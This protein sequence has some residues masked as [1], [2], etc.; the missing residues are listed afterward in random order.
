[1]I[2]S[3]KS[4]R[5]ARKTVR[6][7]GCDTCPFI[8]GR[9]GPLEPFTPH[10]IPVDG[11]E[12]VDAYFARAYLWD[13]GKL[14][15]A[16]ASRRPA[17]VEDAVALA[18]WLLWSTKPE[19]WQRLGIGRGD[20][21]RAVLAVRGL[22]R[23][24]GWRD[25]LSAT[26][27]GQR[28]HRYRPYAASMSVRTEDPARLVA[29]AEE[30]SHRGLWGADV[31]KRGPRKPGL[32]KTSKKEALAAIVG[33]PV[34]E[35]VVGPIAV[36]GGVAW[37]PNDGKM[38]EVVVREVAFTF[39]TGE[40]K[41]GKWIPDG[42]EEQLCEVETEWKMVAGQPKRQEWP[43]TFVA[44][45]VDC[46]NERPRLSRGSGAAVQPD[47]WTAEDH[48]T[49]ENRKPAENEWQEVAPGH[50]VRLRG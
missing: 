40:R 47:P 23:R 28:K 5:L 13:C 31:G 42:Y 41:D 33:E 45:A 3:M 19:Q 26:G 14:A 29:A 30:A 16:K 10:S 50:F 43:R 39:H 11:L 12:A 49:I 22:L 44:E 18:R 38:R 17:A 21:W 1:M 27:H 4:I 36:S 46:G 20:V 34:R 25:K 7:L 35:V 6:E 37:V 9:P 2:R 48:A 8:P 24:S 32:R 15:M